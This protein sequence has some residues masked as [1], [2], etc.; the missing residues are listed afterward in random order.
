MVVI[1]SGRRWGCEERTWRSIPD[2]F[3]NING[4][5]PMSQR[6]IFLRG[7]GLDLQ[8]WL[9]DIQCEGKD[10]EHERGS[11]LSMASGWRG[12]GR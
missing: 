5:P 4:H 9:G 3:G 12:H 2:G 10:A 7:R 8:D 1:E 11:F 6:T